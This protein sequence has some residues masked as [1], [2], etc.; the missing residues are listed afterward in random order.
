MIVLQNFT[1]EPVCFVRTESKYLV[2][3]QWEKSFI[4]DKCS[5]QFLS[6][7]AL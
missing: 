5:L 2:F 6:E 3:N 4:Q 7:E 1:H